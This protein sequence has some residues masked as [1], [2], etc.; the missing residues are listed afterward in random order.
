M[1]RCCINGYPFP[2][3]TKTSIKGIIVLEFKILNRILCVT[4]KKS[5]IL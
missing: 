1:L 3:I 5:T 4:E 2:L